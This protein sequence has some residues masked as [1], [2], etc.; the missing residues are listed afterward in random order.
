MKIILSNLPIDVEGASEQVDAI[1]GCAMTLAVNIDDTQHSPFDSMS[2]GC[3][4][5]Y[6]FGIVLTSWI[7]TQWCAVGLKDLPA[8]SDTATM[9]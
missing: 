5:A 7:S 9:R 6:E 3:L 8:P 1:G 4:T 2:F